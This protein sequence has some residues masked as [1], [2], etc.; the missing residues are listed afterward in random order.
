MVDLLIYAGW[1]PPDSCTSRSVLA[2]GT[3]V[4]GTAAVHN[5][6]E[7]SPPNGDAARPSDRAPLDV[8]GRRHLAGHGPDEAGELTCDR[9]RNHDARF[10]AGIQPSKPSAQSELGLPSEGPHRRR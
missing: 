1:V 4:V 2:L 8:L 5:A 6:I 9:R 7:D 10:A 3:D